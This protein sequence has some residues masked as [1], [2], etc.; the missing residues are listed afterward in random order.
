MKPLKAM[1]ASASCPST[2]REFDLS[3]AVNAGIA[4]GAVAAVSR[5][6]TAAKEFLVMYGGMDRESG[7]TL[8]RGLKKIGQSKVSV[9]QNYPQQAGFAAE[10][11]EVGRRRAEE[12]IAGHKPRTTRV[13]DLPGHVNHPLYDITCKVDAH[14][15]PVPG[16]SAQMKFIG[17]NPKAAADML[18][19]KG[20]RKYIEHNC[21][22]LVPS[23]YYDGIRETLSKRAA[24]LER[25][26]ARLENAGKPDVLSR[27]RAELERCRRLQRNLRKSKVSTTEAMW[28]RKHPKMATAREIALVAHRAGIE[29]MRMGAAFGGGI[30]FVRNAIAVFRGKKTPRDALRDAGRDTVD[31]A[32]AGYAVGAGGAALKGVL[33]NAPWR[34]LR[35]VGKSNLPTYIV[36]SAMEGAK[37]VKRYY[38]GEI[39][40]TQCLEELGEKG[41]GMVNGALYAALGQVLIPIP[42]VGALAGSMLGYALSSASYRILSDSL[43]RAKLA[44]EERKRIEC[45]CSEAIDLLLQCRTEMEVAIAR[46]FALE[47]EVFDRAF[48]RCDATLRMSDADDFIAAMNSITAAHGD[49][50]R[51][52][53]A[54]EGDAF[55]LSDMAFAI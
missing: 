1:Q 55:M 25:E 34:A 52:A 18:M 21:K 9:P 5:Y 15:N 10:E 37:T 39:N 28:A 43:K 23:D 30:A 6:G 44:R 3:G 13:D 45:D 41:C 47:R 29:E 12:A 36:I 7:R 17:G 35:G 20:C 48:T 31:A 40:G 49:T 32:V 11:L 22:I 2:C 16:A 50:P 54:S 46:Y 27:K 4:G 24:S 14:G 53:N 33:K 38:A 42:V 19:G 26:V 8:K 51:F